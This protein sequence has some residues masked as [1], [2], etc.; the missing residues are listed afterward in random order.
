LRGF[1]FNAI[2]CL[3]NFLDG[4]ITFNHRGMNLTVNGIVRDATDV[5]L[6]AM[7]YDQTKYDYA[8]V[9]D[10]AYTAARFNEEGRQE[11]APVSWPVA[12]ITMGAYSAYIDREQSH[13]VKLYSGR[14]GEVIQLTFSNASG[15]IAL[16]QIVLRA[17]VLAQG[18]KER[19]AWQ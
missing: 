18:Q 3:K 15:S 2:D 12:G 4:E 13:T 6:A 8:G 16:K 14:T 7:N 19:V 17:N 9:D 10:F 11:Y 1:H 5:L